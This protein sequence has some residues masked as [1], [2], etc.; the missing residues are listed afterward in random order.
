MQG[1]VGLLQREVRLLQ[2]E[3]RLEFAIN[4]FCL[5][6]KYILIPVLKSQPQK[7]N[8]GTPPSRENL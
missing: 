3:V 1:E 7:T 2:E 5:S 6:L 8:R 4:R